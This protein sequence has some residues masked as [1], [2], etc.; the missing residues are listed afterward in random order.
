MSYN[1]MHMSDIK[2]LGVGHNVRHVKNFFR[3]TGY[4]SYVIM[5]DHILNGCQSIILKLIAS[6]EIT[7]Y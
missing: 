4:L 3:N 7:L 5:F 1:Y 2:S 6:L